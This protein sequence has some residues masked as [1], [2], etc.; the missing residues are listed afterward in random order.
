M[1]YIHVILSS[2][3]WLA[4]VRTWMVLHKQGQFLEQLLEYLFSGAV[5]FSAPVKERIDCF[6]CSAVEEAATIC[7]RR[8][9]LVFIG[10]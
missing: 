6:L 4:A 5:K 2:E 1:A 7:R 10:S 3:K 8:G 9:Y